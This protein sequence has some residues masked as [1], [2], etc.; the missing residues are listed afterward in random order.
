VRETEDF[1]L[2]EE[3]DPWL[4]KSGKRHKAGKTRRKGHVAVA[5]EKGRAE[6][7]PSEETASQG[8][9]GVGGGSAFRH[10]LT[11]PQ[12]VAAVLERSGRGGERSKQIRTFTFGRGA[13]K[14]KTLKGQGCPVRRICAGGGTE[15]G[16]KGSDRLG[17]R[18]D[19]KNLNRV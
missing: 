6:K 3:R 11:L 17:K 7:L 16:P 19:G 14:R 2:K 8:P 5:H 1:Y 15:K 12:G 10:S 9:S 4:E 13:W 18:G